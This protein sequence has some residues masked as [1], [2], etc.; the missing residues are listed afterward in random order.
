V[1]AKLFFKPFRPL[2]KCSSTPGEPEYSRSR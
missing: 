1:E 2:V